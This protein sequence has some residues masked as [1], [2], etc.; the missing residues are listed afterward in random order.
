MLSYIE[1][2]DQGA[3]FIPEILADDGAE[4]LGR[5]AARLRAAMLGLHKNAAADGTWTRSHFAGELAP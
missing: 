5:L 1:G 2:R 3:P 4:R